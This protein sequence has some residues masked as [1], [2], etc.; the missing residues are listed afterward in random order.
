MKEVKIMKQNE[1]KILGRY[2]HNFIPDDNFG[3]GLFELFNFDN[4]K[5]YFTEIIFRNE[6][7][8]KLK[9]FN[10]KQI[11]C[12]VGHIESFGDLVADHIYTK[13]SK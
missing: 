10:E 12:I 9:T 4:T 7:V 2:H 5:S 1:F 13:G 6:L 11:V 3:L 8:E